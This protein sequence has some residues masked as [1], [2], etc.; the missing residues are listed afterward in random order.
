LKRWYPWTSVVRESSD[1]LRPGDLGVFRPDRQHESAPTRYRELAAGR[2]VSRH[3]RKD[4][5]DGGQDD[6]P[7]RER[8]HV[9]APSPLH[10][11]L[12]AAEYE[13][14]EHPVLEDR[15]RQ[16]QRREQDSARRGERDAAPPDGAIGQH[17]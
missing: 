13:Q 10:H 6:R 15:P 4:Q 1:Q 12:E 11:E 8:S 5:K 7:G 9:S 2:V 3:P 14:R 17:A 16:D